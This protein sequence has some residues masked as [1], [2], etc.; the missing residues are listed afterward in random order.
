MVLLHIMCSLLSY[1]AFLVAC[2]AGVLFLIQERQLKRK[3]IGRLCHQLPALGVSERITTMAMGAGVGLLSVG[4]VCGFVGTGTFFGQWWTGDPKEYLTLVLW[5]S[6]L[7]LLGW[8]FRAG[9]RGRR[10]AFL[11]ILGFALVLVTSVGLRHLVVS[12]HPYV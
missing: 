10:V 6:S 3:T 2:G 11:A 8:R 4:T 1:A 5:L 12:M 7:G 9:L